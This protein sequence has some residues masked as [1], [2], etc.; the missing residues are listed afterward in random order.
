MLI[1]EFLRFLFDS[2]FPSAWQDNIAR[3]SQNKQ[4]TKWQ[5]HMQIFH[6]FNILFEL[7][8]SN[9]Q[10]VIS[11][12]CVCT[13]Y[14][15]SKYHENIWRFCATCYVH[16]NESTEEKNQTEALHCMLHLHLDS[17][18][19]YSMNV[20]ST[21]DAIIYGYLKSCSYMNKKK[22]GSF[23]L[24]EPRPQLKY[25]FSH[26]C[27]VLRAATYITLARAVV[28]YTRRR[29]EKKRN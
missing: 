23:D 3:G 12:L 7:G 9:I 20:P 21:D 22:D 10:S 24:N 28:A 16:L 1:L 18:L 27:R 26:C 2:I 29:R 14:E 15:I 6:D 13:W 5:R 25:F 4:Q 17:T 11:V 19:F 8:G